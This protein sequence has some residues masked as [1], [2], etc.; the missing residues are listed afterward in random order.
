MPQRC[1]ARRSIG[2]RILPRRTTRSGS[3]CAGCIAIKPDFASA[4]SNFG[5]LLQ[6]LGRHDE[7]Q[8]HFDKALA[9]KPDIP[10]ALHGRGIFLSALGRL[11][12]A[13][14]T[15]ERAIELD[16]RRAEFYRSLSELKTFLPG[17]PH[18]ALVEALAR[19]MAA[20]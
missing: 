2:N 3:R 1:C 17:E 7:A 14:R 4:H 13:Q 9:I 19:D 5:A 8:V 11:E 10:E 15:L 16:P 18:L 20:L 6:L 12:E